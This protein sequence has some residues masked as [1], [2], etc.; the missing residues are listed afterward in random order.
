MPFSLHF[1]IVTWTEI[2]GRILT[3]T[4][5]RCITARLS[6]SFFMWIRKRRRPVKRG[7]KKK[8]AIALKNWGRWMTP[9]FFTEH[10][11]MMNKCTIQYKVL[12][13]HKVFSIK[14]LFR[15]WCYRTQIKWWVENV[16]GEWDTEWIFIFYTFSCSLF[17][18]WDLS[19][20]FFTCLS[21][22]N[23]NKILYWS[24]LKL[25]DRGTSSSPI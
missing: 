10:L 1:Y 25:T 24:N 19:Y 21:A 9:F 8:L 16:W 12:L 15:T 5:S 23:K 4:V 6:L 22:W 17:F 2:F 3:S 18:C 13:M 20:I 11:G 7:R 14:C